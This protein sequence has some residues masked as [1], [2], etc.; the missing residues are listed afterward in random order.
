MAENGV[1]DVKIAGDG[2]VGGGNFGDVVINGAGKITGDVTCTNFKINGAG[3]AEGNVAAAN[4]IVNGSGNFSG[5]LETK[6]MSINGDATV[7]LG[8][9]VGS[10]KVKGRLTVGGVA[11]HDIDV[12]G[13]IRSGVNIEADS[14]TGEG[15]FRAEGLVNVGSIDF[16]LHGNSSAIEIGGE[17]IS[18]VLGRNFVGA[19]LLSLFGEKRLTA[20][21]IEADEVVLENTTAK[22]VRGGNVSIGTGC[23]IDVVEYSGTL[24]QMPDARIGEARQVAAR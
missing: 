10:L 11:A 17:R 13:E 2:T 22:V 6:E 9:G 18:I 24:N 5:K 14:L 16:K 3:T 15:A 20:D 7:Q 12:R 8:L 19:S 1:N 23:V 21:S 4:T